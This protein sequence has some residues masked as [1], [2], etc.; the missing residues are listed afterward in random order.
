VSS[1][2]GSQIATIINTFDVKQNKE[3]LNVLMSIIIMDEQERMW[4]E[5]VTT[6]SIYN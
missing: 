3:I 2:L 5:A 1:A 6:S 4:K